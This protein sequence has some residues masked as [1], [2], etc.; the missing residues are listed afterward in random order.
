MPS[1]DSNSPET[2]KTRETAMAHRG[3]F[4]STRVPKIAADRPS[5]TMASWNGMAVTVPLSPSASG[6]EMAFLNTLQ[7]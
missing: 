2:K 7:A 4:F 6:C 3:P 1:A 5:M